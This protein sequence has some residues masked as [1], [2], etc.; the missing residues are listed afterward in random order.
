MDDGGGALRASAARFLRYAHADP[1]VSWA[2][3]DHWVLHH[4]PRLWSAPYQGLG[5]RDVLLGYALE[6]DAEFDGTSSLD[7]RA[8]PRPE[9]APALLLQR[10]ARRRDDDEQPRGAQSV[11]GSRGRGM[12]G[13]TAAGREDAAV[14][15]EGAAEARGRALAA[16]RRDLSPQARLLAAGR[17][18]VPRPVGQPRRTTSS[19]RTRR[20]IAGISTTR[21]S[22]SCG[23]RTPPAPRATASA[24]GRSCGSRCGMR[25]FVDRTMSAPAG[26]PAPSTSTSSESALGPRG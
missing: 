2:G 18:V 6:V 21:I 19:F 22:S 16:A 8:P 7:R 26:A 25:M 13:A 4:L 11:H 15:E 17:R 9:R 5:S 3:V 1:L 12:G 10:Q 23:R 14:G 24:S 20:G